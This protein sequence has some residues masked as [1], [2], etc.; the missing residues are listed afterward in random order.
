MFYESLLTEQLQRPVALSNSGFLIFEGPVFLTALS[1][2][3]AVM[4]LQ[5]FPIRDDRETSQILAP[6]GFPI[7]TQLQTFEESYNGWLVGIQADFLII[8]VTNQRLWI[9]QSAIRWI[10]VKLVD[11]K[12]QVF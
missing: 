4:P 11:N 3:W 5:S 9:H 10:K 6:Q 1:L 2:S 12:K 7:Q 8:E